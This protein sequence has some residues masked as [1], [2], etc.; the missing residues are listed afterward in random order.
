MY[1]NVKEDFDRLSTISDVKI[2]PDTNFAELNAYIYDLKAEGKGI[3]ASDY[4][5]NLVQQ[6]N[7]KNPQKPIRLID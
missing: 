2:N 4:I 6:Y 3:S 5:F 7:E 1:K